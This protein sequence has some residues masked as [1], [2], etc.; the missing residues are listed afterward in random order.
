MKLPSKVL[1]IL[2]IVSVLAIV[3]FTLQPVPKPNREAIVIDQPIEPIPTVEPVAANSKTTARVVQP[4]APVLLQAPQAKTCISKEQYDNDPRHQIMEDYEDDEYYLGT[5]DYV[6]YLDESELQSLAGDDN[7]RAMF[8]LAMNYRW[9]A[10]MNTFVSVYVRPEETDRPTYKKRPFDLKM[11]EQARYWFEQAA[12][13][14]RYN[15]VMEIAVSYL[16]QQRHLDKT[17]IDYQ[18][19]LQSIQLKAR[20]YGELHDWLTSEMIE[21]Q[22]DADEPPAALDEQLQQTYADL[23]TNL[24]SG[25]VNN[26]L[27]RGY[28]SKVELN[29]PPAFYQLKALKKQICQR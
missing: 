24:K 20:A 9:H 13:N 6:N 14:G 27:Q 21:L 10:Q 18:Q 22:S 11:M 26:R 17:A 29:L 16:Q 1:L 2:I 28:D 12:L 23:L 5:V 7:V 15:A 4:A 19:Q 3:L 25:W 8:V